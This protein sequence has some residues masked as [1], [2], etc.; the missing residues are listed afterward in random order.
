MQIWTV[1]L[2]LGDFSITAIPEIAAFWQKLMNKILKLPEEKF[3]C[4]QRNY[5]SQIR[6]PLTLIHWNSCLTGAECW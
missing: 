3:V 1:Y 6:I 2:E 5:A 4:R